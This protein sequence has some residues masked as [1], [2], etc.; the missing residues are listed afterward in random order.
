MTHLAWNICFSAI[1]HV[2]LRSKTIKSNT[3]NL[4][5]LS[6]M[7]ENSIPLSRNTSH[8]VNVLLHGIDPGFHSVP[9]HHIKLKSN[10]VSGQVVVGVW[11]TLPVEDISLL[12]GIDMTGDK[13]I[14]SPIIFED[15][16][17]E[18]NELKKYRDFSCMFCNLSQENNFGRKGYFIARWYHRNKWCW[19]KRHSILADVNDHLLHSDCDMSRYFIDKEQKSSLDTDED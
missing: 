4:W 11:P 10:F 17:Y 3:Q 19:I 8:G 7:L 6:L 16:S 12:F 18:E 9:L 15:P 14:K 2:S 1:I 5:L 13:V